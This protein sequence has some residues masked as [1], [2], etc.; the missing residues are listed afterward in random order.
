MINYQWIF[1]TLKK[2]NIG[3]FGN[4]VYAVVWEKLGRD[5][6]GFHG[7][8]KI[9][10]NFDV[11]NLDIDNFVD[12]DQITPE[13]LISWIESIED[14]GNVNERIQEEIDRQRAQDTEVFQGSMPWD[15]KPEPEE[16][17]FSVGV[18]TDASMYI[19]GEYEEPTEVGVSTETGSNQ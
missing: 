6:E 12:Y 9:A 4:V 3:N 16:E 13:T 17:F 18:S 7:S 14:Q 19:V 8:F 2:K 10:T 1:H 15:P 5:E 11:S